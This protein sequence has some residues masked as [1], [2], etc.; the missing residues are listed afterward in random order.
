MENQLRFEEVGAGVIHN[1]VSIFY[2][3][4]KHFH[5]FLMMLK[6]PMGY[7]VGIERMNLR[8]FNTSIRNATI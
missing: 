2:F 3:E 8:S 6:Y 1:S 5:N 4:N 7:P